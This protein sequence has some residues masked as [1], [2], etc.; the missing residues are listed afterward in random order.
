MQAYNF[1]SSE[2]IIDGFVFFGTS[3]RSIIASSGASKPA[4]AAEAQLASEVQ[5][6][7]AGQIASVQNTSPTRRTYKAVDLPL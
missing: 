4:F 5:E 6:G 3:Q 1:P 7:D 2:R